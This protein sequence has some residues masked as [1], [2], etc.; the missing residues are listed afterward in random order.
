MDAHSQNPKNAQGLAAET[1]YKGMRGMLKAVHAERA[2]KSIP[3]KRPP[4]VDAAPSVGLLLAEQVPRVLPYEGPLGG[5]L[6][7]KAPPAWTGGLG[8]AGIG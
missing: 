5:E 1:R 2:Q 8:V 6:R 4:V 3:V 7:R